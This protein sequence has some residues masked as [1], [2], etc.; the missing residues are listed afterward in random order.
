VA[1]LGIFFEPP[2]GAE[3]EPEHEPVL[4]T[5]SNKLAYVQSRVHDTLVGCREAQLRAIKQ[6]FQE[7]RVISRPRS[8]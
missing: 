2:A 6:G 1:N 8:T 5:D 7:V 3:E 4:V